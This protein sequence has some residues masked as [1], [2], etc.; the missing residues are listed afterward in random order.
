MQRGTSGLSDA[1]EAPLM[2]KAAEDREEADTRAV[3]FKIT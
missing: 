3:S 1:W 2:H